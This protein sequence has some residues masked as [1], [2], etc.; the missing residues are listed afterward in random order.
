[1]IL[2]FKTILQEHFLKKG[3]WEKQQQKVEAI[4]TYQQKDGVNN[5]P[6]QIIINK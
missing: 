5:S 6:L 1:M 2:H 4:R 3:G